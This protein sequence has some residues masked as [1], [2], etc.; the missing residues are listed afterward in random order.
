MQHAP[1]KNNY[2]G[3]KPQEFAA[4]ESH[5]N[6]KKP[7]WLRARY[8]CCPEVEKI[9]QI[10]RSN[11]LHTV[12][13]E[14]TCPNL[15]ECFKQ[16]T[17]TFLILGDR[18]TRNC[19]FCDVTHGS[20]LPADDDEP[21]NLARA[22]A[23]MGLRYVVITSVTRD[24]LPDGGSGQYARTIAAIRSQ[25][26]AIQIEILVPDFRGEEDRAL[27][28]L[29]IDPPDVF[30]HNL[31]TVSSLYSTVRPEANYDGSL[32]LLRLYKEMNPSLSTKSGIM[33][34]FGETQEEVFVAMQDLRNNHCNMLTLGQYLR[35]SSRHLPVKRYV[36]PE[37]F[38]TSRDV[39]LSM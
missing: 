22:V 17:A 9:R 4:E 25:D 18:C 34:G 14:A 7:E 3:T 36:P 30:N 16:G 29:S 19:P 20:P 33:L 6:L 32:A 10:L 37:E 11:K 24:D 28:I 23:S 12:C 21:G 31:E 26:P 39:G 5:K 2:E 1:E 27:K 13:E 35:P 8:T 15:G 38:A